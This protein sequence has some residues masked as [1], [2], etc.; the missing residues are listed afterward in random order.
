MMKK[1][2]SLILV[3]F[4]VLGAFFACEKRED[5]DLS[6]DLQGE[7]GDKGEQGEQGLQGE[8]G[9]KG[10]QGE[11]GL[12]GE[13][14][15]KGEQGE[16]GLQ[17]EKGDK[18]EQGE[19]GLQGEKGDK[20]EQGEQGAQG[21]KGDSYILSESDKLEIVD[22]IENSK[23]GLPEYWIP[24]LQDGTK[25]INMALCEAGANKSSFLFY[26]D[27][28]WNYGS[29]MSPLLLKYLYK[30]TGITKTVF[31]GDIVNDE[32]SDYDDM[33]YLWEWRSMIK[34]LPNHHSVVGNH[35]DGNGTNNLFSEEYVYGYLLA[36]E[37]TSDV[38][39][40]EGMYYYIDNTSEKTRYLYLDTAY[41][42]VDQSQKSFVDQA[43]KT[44]PNGWHI[45]AVSHIW[46]MPDYD[47]YD[48]RPVPLTGLSS[49]ARVLTEMFDAYNSRS[50]EYASCGGKV[51]FCIGGH[52]H[53]DYDGRTETG[54]PIILVETDSRH[55]RGSYTYTAGTTTEASVNGIIADYDNNIIHVIRVGR[56][57][58]RKVKIDNS[59][60]TYTNVLPSALDASLS[61][62]Y[63]ETG[64]KA[65]TR[66][67]SSTDM[68]LLAD[69]SYISGYIPVSNGD[70]IR[71]SNCNM[72]FDGVCSVF[73]Y[74][75]NNTS[76]EVWGADSQILTEYY[77]SVWEDGE[78]VQFTVV[79]HDEITH[80]RIQ[81]G[82]FSEN[83]VVTV[84]EA[85][86]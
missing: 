43:L 24:A 46:Y 47:N 64:W 62:V 50:G 19:Q 7:K 31:G 23:E 27:S 58:S 11:Q 10:E 41:K 8:K 21:E 30:N 61:G 81:G 17:G 37:E 48:K 13:K 14:G 53:Y 68:E 74:E 36:P 72:K 22:R 15:D 39:H 12:Q 25:A 71:I 3:F 32:S 38:V 69:G 60:E 44:T 82:G 65:N 76:L 63:N 6:K 9:D 16:R 84:N 51:E 59:A 35:D 86:E 70:I 29:K 75:N 54:I 5:S 18:G 42:G 1:I 28:H 79:A 85:I 77:D 34:D 45:V 57:N 73:G 52:V 66:W 55:I 4:M 20:G 80:I 67:S 78:L 26:S 40:G 49:N 83:S 2:L 56:G 33:S